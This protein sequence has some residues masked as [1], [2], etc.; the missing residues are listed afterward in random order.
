M[1]KITILLAIF[2]IFT[3]NFSNCQE[4]KIEK[5]GDFFGVKS[6][7][8]W[9]IE[10]IYDQII[11]DENT[12][13]TFHVK[14]NNLFGLVNL[15]VERQIKPISKTMLKFE[16]ATCF[17]LFYDKI[18]YSYTKENGQKAF[19]S[20]DGKYKTKCNPETIFPKK[21]GDFY[22]L[23]GLD[24]VDSKNKAQKSVNSKFLHLEKTSLKA[25]FL[26]KGVN[27]KFGIINLCGDTILPFENESIDIFNYDGDGNDQFILGRE[28]KKIL[29][30]FNTKTLLPFYYDEIFRVHKENHSNVFF[31]KNNGKYGLFCTELIEL[32][33]PIY[34][35]L[36]MII[37]ED[38]YGGTFNYIAQK[39]GKYY[40]YT[41]KGY[42]FYK[43]DSE[44]ILKEYD[45]IDGKFGVIKKDS[46]YEF[47]NLNTHEIIKIINESDYKK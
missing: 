31:V 3:I 37:N 14:K 45:Q 7:D 27:G 2:T 18:Y 47:Y 8:N 23:F 46:N 41:A 4:Y 13:Y 11:V 36:E 42:F 43:N 19:V 29:F 38:E 22:Y 10:P 39:S 30:D 1:K 6:D 40:V 15:Y 17:E 24:A 25:L 32:L 44:V 21:D 26:A 33:P 12:D 5:Q 34:D 35:K 20:D 9:I 16:G 28:G